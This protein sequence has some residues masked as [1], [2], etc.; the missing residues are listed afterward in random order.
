MGALPTLR[1]A[2]DPA[3]RGAQYYGP[4][5]R[6]EL[7][8]SPRLVGSSPD[9]HDAT[10]QRRLWSVSETLTGVTFPV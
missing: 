5:G 1:A 6:G 9:S 10:V 7:R 4:G 3:V 2:T 8:G